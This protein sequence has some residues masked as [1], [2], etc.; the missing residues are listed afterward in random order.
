M[1]REDADAL[2][3]HDAVARALRDQDPA[4]VTRQL[5][6]EIMRRS[7]DLSAGAFRSWALAQPWPKFC[8]IVAIVS[9][10]VRDD[11]LRRADLEDGDD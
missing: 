6:Q 1:T 10:S 4:P 5:A 7:H 2:W 11:L 3:G 8:A 9:G